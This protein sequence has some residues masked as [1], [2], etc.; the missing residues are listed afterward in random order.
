MY[1]FLRLVRLHTVMHIFE[2]WFFKDNICA[3]LALH[4]TSTDHLYTRSSKHIPPLILELMRIHVTPQHLHIHIRIR[5]HMPMCR[6]L[7][8]DILI[9]LWLEIG[10]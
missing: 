1:L 10:P 5:A 2:S 3:V 8:T 7:T 6:D 9:S 4:C